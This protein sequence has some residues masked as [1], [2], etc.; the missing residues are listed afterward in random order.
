MPEIGLWD[1]TSVGDSWLTC[2]G[3]E[4]SRAT[5]AAT[6][7]GGSDERRAAREHTLERN[8]RHLRELFDELLATEATYLD[9]MRFVCDCFL[10][11]LR[12]LLAPGLVA[13][14]L[15]CCPSD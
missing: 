1:F 15:T 5:S 4:A 2:L 11:P 3:R 13:E 7:V 14:G 12:E 6:A 8:T 9:D 10:V